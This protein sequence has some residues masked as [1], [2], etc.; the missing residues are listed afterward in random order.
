MGA[1]PYPDTTSDFA[2]ANP[3]AQALGKQHGEHFTAEST[4]IVS[5][6]VLIRT[7]KGVLF[8]LC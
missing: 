8:C 2:A 3:V 5:G 1:L 7:H 4:A 6:R